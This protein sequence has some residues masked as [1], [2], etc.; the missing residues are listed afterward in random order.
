MLIMLNNVLLA[1]D[2]DG[3][4]LTDDNRILEK[5]KAAIRLLLDS[6]GLFTIATGR[7]VNFAR[8]IA[9]ELSLEIPAVIF[10]GAAV[11]D[12]NKDCFLWQCT[13]PET[14]LDYV[15][16]FKENFPTLGI[17]ILRGKDV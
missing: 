9:E 5:D 2:A 14:A 7:A 4:L 13:L 16:L 10:N 3:T 11:Y 15:L 6:G 12:Y 8:P 17:E 1:A